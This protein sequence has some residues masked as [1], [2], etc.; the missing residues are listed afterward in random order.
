MNVDLLL[1]NVDQ[2]ECM[3]NF[4]K[5]IKNVIDQAKELRHE[6][7]EKMDTIEA[8]KAQD[9]TESWEGYLSP[10]AELISS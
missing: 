9:P 3:V 6:M 7:E 4:K 1:A 5:L 10:V 8:P 2:Y